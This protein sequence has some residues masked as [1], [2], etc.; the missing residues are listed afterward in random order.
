MKKTDISK[1]T[2]DLPPED[3]HI[4]TSA[5]DVAAS[6]AKRTLSVIWRA[7][8]TVLLII[9]TTGC[10]VGF[11]MMIYILG[12]ADESVGFNLKHEK[13]ELV[14]VI[15]VND[16]QG[17]PQEYQRVAG[18]SREWVDFQD[19]P[20]AMKDAIVAIEDKRFYKHKGV[21][22]VRTASAVFSLA[23]GKDNFGGST[24]TQQLIKNVTGNDE[25]SLTRK[26]KEIF[27][28]LNFEKEYSK[29]DILEAYLNIVN[30]GSGC[31][32]VQAAANLY[33]GKDIQD[34]TI[35][36]C[37][38]I[39]GITQN[40]SKYTPLVHPEWNK[41]RQ[42][43][44]LTEM[45]D[46]GKIDD[47]EFEQA[48]EESE[49]M[50]F[51][52]WQD[53]DDDNDTAEKV[54]NWYIEVMLKDLAKDL[55]DTLNVSQDV[56]QNMIR[57]QGLKIYSAMDTKAQSAAESVMQD[58]TIMP[59]DKKIQAG[60]LMMDYSGRVLASVGQR[61]PKEGN[62][63][64]DCANTA[65]R[66]PGST[67]KPIATYTPAVEYLGYTYSQM[68]PNQQ[69]LDVAKNEDGEFYPWPRNW[70]NTYTDQV[71]LQDALERSINC[72][73]AYT[74]LKVT[75][76]VSYDFL[77]SKLHIT[78][79]DPTSAINNPATLTLGAGEVTVREM[80]AAYQIYGNQGI[81]NKPYTYFYV[82]DSEG[83]I[84]ID[85]R[86]KTG[87][88]VIRPSTATI[89]RRALETV[90]TGSRGTARGYRISG[91]QTFGKTGTTTDDKDSFFIAGSPYA[92]AGVWTGYEIPKRLQ[93]TS[94][95][96][97]IWREIMTR[98]LDGKEV[99]PFTDNDEVVQETYCL[100]SGKLAVPGKCTQT[101]TG[102][103]WQRNLP[104]SCTLPH[105][106]GTSSSEVSSAASSTPS[107]S[108]P[109]S[110]P[111]SA[112]SESSAV[113]SEP[114]D[115]SVPESSDSSQ[116]T[117]TEVESQTSSGGRERFR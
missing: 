74:N 70:D 5:G 54:N 69:L 21:D 55:A 6:T 100:D 107:S 2:G 56:A 99:I 81:Y 18:T 48:M 47:A 113:S 71:T 41:E 66:Q 28:A 44:V 90:F 86:N 19:I 30:F 8:L 92:V 9:V 65:K 85:N 40:P 38:S 76:Q 29:D 93:S 80:V 34:C 10:I 14:S 104:G 78:S 89:I 103:Y 115:S 64:Y 63:L 61:G 77:S 79:L 60:F 96:L 110:Q 26:V 50:V 72:P 67:M 94:H 1:Y 75:R 84:L 43:I 31:E 45:H 111:S 27:S 33:F 91:W 102:Y 22:L 15:Y 17:N 82:E 7:V 62:L 105:E 59:A 109:S 112:P 24:I 32:G 11:S 68:I 49:H 58:D 114:P 116:A 52:G 83:K 97:R 37:A 98:Y 95:S 42:Q 3:F 23:L 13:L 36:E 108:Q 117:S 4:G 73:A 46:Q 106:E 87:E 51:V 53:D 35:A 88:Q 101:A 16:E 25:V 57:H 20:K 39:A 12:M